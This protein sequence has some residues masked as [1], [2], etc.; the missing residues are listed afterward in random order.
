LLGGFCWFYCCTK[1][2]K[3]ESSSSTDNNGDGKFISSSLKEKGGA[4]SWDGEKS[5]VGRA[6]NTSSDAAGVVDVEV[7]VDVWIEEGGKN[8]EGE[9]GCGA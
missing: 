4:G 7:V 6:E 8:R 5:V 3:T 2:T 1:S 9:S